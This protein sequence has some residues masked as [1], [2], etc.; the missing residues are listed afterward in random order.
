MTRQE[1]ERDPEAEAEFDRELAKLTADSLD[2]RKFERRSMFDVPLPIRRNDRTPV[3]AG[4]AA[5]TSNPVDTMAFSLLTKKGNRQQTR[6]VDM[7]A[8][9]SFAVAMKTKQQAERDEQKRIKDLVLN[10]DLRSDDQEIADRGSL[11]QPRLDRTSFSRNQGR[12]RKLQMNN[13]DWT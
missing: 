13:M 5:E 6:T 2:S 8:D 12:N 10:Y 7:P 11:G 1:E 4:K 9:S 3:D